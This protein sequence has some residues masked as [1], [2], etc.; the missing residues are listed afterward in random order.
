MNEYEVRLLKIPVFDQE[1]GA[2][3]REDET[4][5]VCN[6]NKG[7]EN[8]PCY[9]KDAAETLCAFLNDLFLPK[10]ALDCSAPFE[11]MVMDIQVENERVLYGNGLIQ[12][13]A[14]KIPQYRGGY[15]YLFFDMGS[16][17]LDID[18]PI[19]CVNFQEDYIEIFNNDNGETTLLKF[20]E[21]KGFVFENKP[22]TLDEL[23]DE[24]SEDLEDDDE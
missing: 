12:R 22:L 24:F 2:E 9:D 13:L 10:E 14:E 16:V 7:S 11:E 20:S 15:M 8:Y 21:L 6:K 4:Y 17:K 19:N 23:E 18:D 3:I 1:T 5:T